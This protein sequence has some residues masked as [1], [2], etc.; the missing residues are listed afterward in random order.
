MVATLP[1]WLGGGKEIARAIRSESGVAA[2][3]QA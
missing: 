1:H 3:P 2:P